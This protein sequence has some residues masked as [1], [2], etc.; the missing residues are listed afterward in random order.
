MM[1]MLVFVVA[2]ASY[3]KIDKYGEFFIFMM[4]AVTHK[5]KKLLNLKY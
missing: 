4:R 5:I 2:A 1:M 3:S